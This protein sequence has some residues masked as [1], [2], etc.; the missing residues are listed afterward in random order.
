MNYGS[1]LAVATLA[2]SVSTTV[3]TVS[4]AAADPVALSV[5]VV[6]TEGTAKEGR[7]YEPAA[8]PVV[9]PAGETTAAFNVKP[10]LDGETD[11]DTVMSV[12]IA[13]GNV[14]EVGSPVSVTI[15]NRSFPADKNVWF[16][17]DGNLASTAVNWSKGHMPTADDDVLLDG[18]FSK[19]D[20]IWDGG[21]NGLGDTVKS[22][23]QTSSYT[24][25]V[26]VNTTFAAADPSFTNLTVTGD[27][28]IDGGTLSPKTHGTSKNPTYRLM[29]TVGGNF[30]VGAGAKVSAAGLGRYVD[31]GLWGGSSAHGGDNGS[32]S[33]DKTTGVEKIV[34]YNSA[35]PA[36]GAMLAPESVAHGC[37]SGTDQDSK[38]CRGGGAVRLAVAGDFRNDGIVDVDGGKAYAAAAAGGSIY[39][40]ARNIL[41]TGTYTSKSLQADKTD[42]TGAIGSGGRIALVAGNAN[43]ATVDR[44]TCYGRL[45][46]WGRRGGAGTVYLKSALGAT[47]SVKGFSADIQTTTPIPAADDTMDWRHCAKE[48]DLVGLDY[49]HLRLTKE[50]IWMKSVSLKT[51]G[52]KSDL[53][54][55]G[56]VIVLRKVFI[57]GVDQKLMPGDYTYARAVANGWTWLKDASYV[58]AVEDDPDT[59]D[60]DESAAAVEGTGVLRIL[61]GGF[62][63]IL[64]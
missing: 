40:T 16:P 49:A 28:V 32:Y 21:V 36:F 23:T 31:H 38:K 29:M 20:M 8:N 51:A 1:K 26:T 17:V 58:P 56:K 3:L 44:I 54:L 50:V 7:N 18:D 10:L 22:W 4:R 41:G 33:K 14:A 34:R 9:I 48:I 35:D 52:N 61:G 57:D 25:L 42:G 2:L 39:V 6:S 15:E 12:S 24:G 13:A 45:E 37:S 64:R 46:N 59:A 19:A 11:A 62:A 55:D 63:L 30:T 5:D 60:V 43:E 47:V 53:D 27:V